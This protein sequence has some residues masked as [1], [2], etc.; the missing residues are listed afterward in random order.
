MACVV[1]GRLLVLLLIMMLMLMMTCAFDACVFQATVPLLSTHTH[2]HHTPTRPPTHPPTNAV[3]TLT[4]EYI[5]HLIFE[6]LGD[7]SIVDVL[8]KLMKLPWSDTEPYLLKCLLK[9]RQE[10]EGGVEGGGG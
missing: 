5:H 9:V 3:I 7:G 4:Q 8:K 2:T 1:S 10:E 6:R